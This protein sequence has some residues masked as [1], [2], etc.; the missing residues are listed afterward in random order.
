MS[1][2][3]TSDLS[4]KRVECEHC[5]AIWING[6]HTWRTGA[7]QDGSEVDLAGLVCNTRHGGGSLCINP[8]KGIE[9]G[10][11]WEKRFSDLEVMTEEYKAN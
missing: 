2:K 7:Q 6:V 4:I 5:G 1:E 9:G 8:Q 10:D 11:T 3:Q